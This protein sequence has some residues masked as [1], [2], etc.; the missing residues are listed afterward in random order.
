MTF[1]TCIY[2]DRYAF[3]GMAIL[4]AISIGLVQDIS[5]QRRT[6]AAMRVVTR[7]AVAKFSRK[8]GMLLPHRP[9]RVTTLTKRLG[10]LD[11]KVGVGRL[12]RL[13]AGGALSLGVGHMCILEF[14]WHPGVAVEADARGTIIE[15]PGHIRGMR[16]V[17]A[18]ALSTFN[19]SMH[20]ALLIIDKIGMTGV[21][22]VLYLLLQQAAEFGNMGVVA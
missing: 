21:T 16:V 14:L 20:H 15:Q 5:D 4:A 6:V 10:L 17:A 9:E 11:Q 1:E 12:M 22:Q 7:T 18:Q 13:M 2:R 19:R 8:V 3:T